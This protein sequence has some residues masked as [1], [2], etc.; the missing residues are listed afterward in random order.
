MEDLISDINNMFETLVDNYEYYDAN[1][2]RYN[3]LM[4]RN[5]KNKNTITEIINF[6]ID[7]MDINNYYLEENNNSNEE[8]YEIDDYKIMDDEDD[9][10]ENKYAY[11]YLNFKIFEGTKTFLELCKDN[12]RYKKFIKKEL[13]NKINNEEI[14]FTSD[15]Y[16]KCECIGYFY[17]DDINELYQK[18]L[19]TLIEKNKPWLKIVFVEFL[20]NFIDENKLCSTPN[21]VNELINKY[22]NLKEEI[23]QCVSK[24]CIEEIKS[25]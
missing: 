1:I 19:I 9:E 6:I 12:D 21:K 8:D 23:N 2:K 24:L 22:P 16:G 18:Y 20:K 14:D 7:N 11:A 25:I 3:N 5:Y 15:F 17:E 10:D 4:H 13:V